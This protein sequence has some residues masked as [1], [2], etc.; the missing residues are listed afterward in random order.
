MN[1]KKN[2]EKPGLIA[3]ILGNR[4]PRC[5][6]GHLFK[7]RNPYL[8][9]KVFDMHTHCPVCGQETELEPGFWYGTGYL[10]YV[11]CVA[12]SVF[13]LA[14]YWLIFGLS[15][16]DDSVIYWLII[17]GVLLILAMPALMRWSRTMYLSFFVMY[18]PEKVREE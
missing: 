18:D 17:N 6:S 1:V 5:R 7:N 12:L 2:K 16:R 9:K 14:W 4:C 3:C 10:S 13:N 8:L 15:W 11:I